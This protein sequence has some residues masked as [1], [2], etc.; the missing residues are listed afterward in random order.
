MPQSLVSPVLVGRQAEVDILSGALTRARAGEPMTVVLGGEAGV[1]KSRLVQE[2]IAAAGRTEVRVLLGGCVEL[3]GGGIPFAPMVEMIRTLAAELPADELDAVLGFAREE[4]SRLVPELDDGSAPASTDDRDPSRPL[5]LMLGVVGRVSATAPLLIVFED[6]Q[7]ADPATLDLL[8]MLVARS[9]GRRLMLVLTVRSDEL[10]RAHPFRRIA[11]RWEQQRSVE[12]L[13]LHR[14]E[15]VHVAA[16]IEAILGERPAGDLVVSIAE[17]SEGIPLFVEELLNATRDGH[18]DADYLPPSLRDVLLARAESL[19]SQAQHVLRVVS[20]GASW[21]PDR[22][23]SLVAE[24]PDLELHRALREVV[25]AQLLVVEPSGRGYGFRHTLARAAIHDDLLP[26]ERTQLHRAYAQALEDNPELTGSDLDSS[27]MLAH[28]WLSAHDLP[29]ALPAS[30]RAGRAAAAAGAP[31]AA[32][33]HF[34]RALELWQQVPDAEQRAGID[35]SLLLQAASS[36]AARSGAVDRGLA[37]IDQALAEIGYGGTLE[38]RATLLVDR[39]DLLSQLGRDSEALAV[40]EQAEALLPRDMPSRLSAQVLSAF[41]RMLVRVDRIERAGELAQRALEAAEAAGATEEKLQSQIVLTTALVYGGEVESG[42]ALAAQVN[43]EAKEAGLPWIT[44]RALIIMTDLQLML[45]RYEEAVTAADRG[46][47]F[48]EQSGFGRTVGA[49]LRSNKAEALLR[50]GQWDNVLSVAAP[51]AE[52]PGIFAAALLLLRAELYACSGRLELGRSDLREARRHLRNTTAA[53]FALP[54]AMIDGELLRASGDLA[55]ASAAVAEVLARTDLGDEHRYKWPVLSLGARVEAER[56]LAS[57]DV[58]EGP[59]E[60]E[61]R[62][63]ELREEA[64]RTKTTT[65]ADRGHQAMVRA[66]HARVLGEEEPVAWGAAVA[67]CREM[68]EPL[69]LS[70]ALLRE[71]EALSASSAT[72]S[73]AERA[74][75]ARE[76]AAGM[77]AAPLLADVEALI[78]RARLSTDGGRAGAERIQSTTSAERERLG[79]TAREAEVLGLVADGLSNSQI[80]QELYISR[81]TASVHVS[82]ILSKLGVHSRV[83]AAALAHRRGLARASAE[84]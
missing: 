1:G 5:E 80:A 82:N 31:S 67:A 48:A 2:L 32:Q 54:L 26:G 81:K 37:L 36:A 65:P 19:S 34:E 13:E 63:A 40:L 74:A 56:A 59:G 4:I 64:D 35:H 69:P 17:R 57:R 79:L 62:I 7:W 61:R 22:L 72:A 70:Y 14:L 18:L 53:Q 8:A 6:V 10:H 24:L 43:Q 21:V 66:E 46:I 33:R 55:Q 15:P 45:G 25:E 68:N 47:A 28:H 76:L 49:I 12:R 11:A 44:G 77:G 52:A 29:R 73:A 38:R 58:G 27:S 84:A 16:Q 75:E 20:A 83:E 60:A 30:V 23:L 50:S 9:G 51:G 78:R 42:M 39:A 41:A 3:D 71:A